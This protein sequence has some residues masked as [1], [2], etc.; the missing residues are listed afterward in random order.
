MLDNI[1]HIKA[2]WIMMTPRITQYAQRSAADDLDG[3]V[4]EEKIYHKAGATTSQG[5]RHSELLRLI[6]EARR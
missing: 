1:S 4:V 3:T 5:I 6:H 2:Y